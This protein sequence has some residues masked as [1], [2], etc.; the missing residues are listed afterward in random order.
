MSMELHIKNVC[1]S[2]YSELYHI[3][4]IWHLLSVDSRKTVVSLFVLSRL[5]YC[6][7]LL[8]GCPTH[9]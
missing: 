6:N 3:S 7:S 1:Q 5:D 8:S 9:L 4:T 2:A